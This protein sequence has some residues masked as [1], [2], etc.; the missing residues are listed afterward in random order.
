MK[1]GFNVISRPVNALGKD[2][3]WRAVDVVRIYGSDPLAVALPEH[4]NDEGVAPLLGR[5]LRWRRL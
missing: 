1:T 3:A 2:G 5:Q 4:V